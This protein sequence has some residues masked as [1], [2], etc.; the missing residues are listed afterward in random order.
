MQNF[1]KKPKNEKS[2]RMVQDR[3]PPTNLMSP[4]PVKINL[5]KKRKKVQ[6]AKM[7][8]MLK[9]M[10]FFRRQPFWFIVTSSTFV[11]VISKPPSFS[12]QND[13]LITSIIISRDFFS[14]SLIGS[15]LHDLLGA[16]LEGRPGPLRV[17]SRLRHLARLFW[18]QICVSVLVCI[19]LIHQTR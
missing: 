15:P 6:S 2:T 8:S 11:F 3:I 1:K 17:F 10:N 4:T 7:F 14:C 13:F 9:G 18:N 5:P 19:M 16:L 12:L